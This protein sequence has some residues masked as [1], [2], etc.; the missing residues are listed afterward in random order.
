MQVLPGLKEGAV[1]AA[2]T[3]VVKDG[4]ILGKPLNP[5]Q[6]VEMLRFLSGS[7]HTVITGICVFDILT[8]KKLIDSE[9]TVVYFRD[10]SEAEI[11]RYVFSG[12]PFDKAGGYGI[13]GLGALFVARIEGCFYNVVGLPLAK[14]CTM[15]NFVGISLI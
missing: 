10:L 13:Q 7:K 14:L 3:I 2:D 5:E 8:G 1:L 6:A 11:E 9:S 15:L 12:E 4:S